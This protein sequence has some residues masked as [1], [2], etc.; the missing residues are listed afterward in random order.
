[1]RA[2]CVSFIQVS[3]RNRSICS[4]LALQNASLW[5]ANCKKFTAK[6][7]KNTLLRSW[8]LR[9]LAKADISPP[10]R[11]PTPT[12]QTCLIASRIGSL[13]NELKWGQGSEFKK[14]ERFCNSFLNWLL[15]LISSLT[16]SISFF[17][18]F[19]SN[20]AI[21]YCHSLIVSCALLLLLNEKRHF[22]AHK[23]MQRANGP[24]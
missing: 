21:H 20:F 24:S 19:E 11:A 23:P 16:L 6:C 12:Q 1:M 2:A 3:W 4:R 8:K 9:Q 10:T 17:H 14:E 18:W 22:F 15:I 5:A 13:A 7:T